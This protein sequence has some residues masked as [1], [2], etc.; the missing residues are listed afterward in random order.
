MFSKRR[1]FIVACT[2]LL[3]LTI[4]SLAAMGTYSRSALQRL[5]GSQEAN[6]VVL[7]R[8]LINTLWPVYSDYQKK[9][10]DFNGDNLRAHPESE[11][12]DRD[13]HRITKGL[14]I[15]KVKIYH[16]N[17][18]TIYSSEQRQIGE[19]KSSDSNFKTTVAHGKTLS[20]LSYRDTFSAFSGIRTDVDLVET[21]I[22]ITDDNGRVLTVFEVY[23]DVTAAI[24]AMEREKMQFALILLPIFALLFAAMYFA[25]RRSGSSL[26]HQFNNLSSFNESLEQ[27]VKERTA[28]ADAAVKLARRT[29]NQVSAEIEERKRIEQELIEK[30][31]RL[32]QQQSGLSDFIRNDKL[33]RLGWERALQALMEMTATT[34][35]VARTSTWLFTPDR[36]AIRCVDMFETSGN[37][38]SLGQM[39]HKSDYP[40][41]FGALECDSFIAADDALVDPRTVEFRNSYLLPNG[42]S[43]VLDV[44]IIRD[45][46]VEGVVC[47]EHVGEQMNWSPDQQVFA[48]AVA[49][50]AAVVLEGRDRMLVEH[51]LR[52]TN[53]ALE[54]ATNAKSE[55]LAT[56]SH[57]IRTPMNGVLGTLELLLDSPLS[58]GQKNLAATARSSAESLLVILNDILDYSKLEA[59]KV[60]LDVVDFSP[61]QVVDDIVSL[62]QSRAKS[63]GLSIDLS[64]ASNVP[65]WLAGDQAR[66][67]QVL[68]NLI[69]NAIKFTEQGGV[70]VS[71]RYKAASF[72]QSLVRFEIFDTGIGIPAEA[73][74]RLFE[75]FSQTDSSTTRKF[76]GTGLGLAIS[77]QIVQLM[78]GEIGV[79]T[80]VDEGCT[81][82]FEVPMTEGQQ[83]SALDEQAEVTKPSRRLRILVADDN[84]VN[85]M[86]AEMLLAKQ[87]HTVETAVNGL[88]AVAAVR[89]TQYDLVLMDVQ[90]P[91]MDGITATSQIRS[92]AGPE[93]NVKIIAL[94]ANAMT[95]QREEYLAN[96]MNDYVSKPINSKLLFAAIERVASGVAIVT[97][98]ML[99]IDADRRR[100]SRRSSDAANDDQ[101]GKLPVFDKS[102]IAAWSSGMNQADVSATL[103]CVPDESVK[104]LNEIKAAIAAGDLTEAKRIAHRMK[105]M[106]SNLGAARLAAV[107]RSIELDAPSIEVVSH[108]LPLLTATTDE[109]L[110]Q[111]RAIA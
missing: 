59:A 86:I 79:I 51:E 29:S 11:Q 4:I 95:G 103:E 27:R 42:I 62:F 100:I 84:R 40:T 33:T 28:E 22:P 15:L 2:L 102:V 96:G 49:S 16:P 10:T 109:T 19:D 52:S 111:L 7:G 68:S 41:Y 107:A 47:I 25:A 64:I 57:E 87:G 69:G 46:Q 72:G 21:Y 92:L 20:K 85:R 88:E 56:M 73:V 82:W 99:S 60:E 54:A 18:A 67:R 104:S 24:I 12:L 89:K 110:V 74:G 36:R 105:G 93:C 34:L 31:M 35:E 55:F 45:G 75:R 37:R 78:G 101:F 66:L 83:P 97:P 48:A 3:V 1:N 13:L 94:T 43:S 90:M 70:S 77:K 50:L 30:Q 53:R 23:T 5:I 80:D 81:F 76:G 65:L 98:T 38:H 14:P 91:E 108:R 32:T 9:L 71:C 44:P 26:D 8:S 63:K 6:N 106:A 39:L 17:G 61:E 58:N